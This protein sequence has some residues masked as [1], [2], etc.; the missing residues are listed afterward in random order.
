MTFILL[1]NS[2][3]FIWTW[4]RLNNKIINYQQTTE[5]FCDYYYSTYDLDFKLL[6]TV[7]KHD[8]LFT[9]NDKEFI[10]FE[11]LV[12]H[13]NKLGFY[14]VTHHKQLTVNAQPLGDKSVLINI[15][16]KIS[17]NSNMFL[18]FVETVILTKHSDGQIYVHNTIFKSYI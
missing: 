1:F 13:F 18:P 17:F 16:G 15:Y 6:N 7:Y 5:K 12:K 3:N 9:F 8:S 4:N 2:M 10:G 14:K 11:S